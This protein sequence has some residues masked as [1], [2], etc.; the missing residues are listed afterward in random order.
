VSNIMLRLHTIATHPATPSTHRADLVAVLAVAEAAVRW[1]RVHTP[2]Q[3]VAY[4]VGMDL[5]EAVRA[6]VDWPPP[7][8]KILKCRCATCRWYYPTL[9]RCTLTDRQMQ[10]VE[11]CDTW[12]DICVV[13]PAPPDARNASATGP[14]VVSGRTTP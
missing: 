12:D 6:M 8:P 2:G 13:P 1:E 14:M 5:A 7:E 3:P 10:P 9:G 4:V 11:T